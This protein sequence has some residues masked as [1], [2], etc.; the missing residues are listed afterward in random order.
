METFMSRITTARL[1]WDCIQLI[2]QCTV[3]HSSNSNCSVL[4]MS[5]LG[6]FLGISVNF[7]FHAADIDYIL[8]YEYLESPSPIG[9]DVEKHVSII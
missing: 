2:S 1:M 4:E 8:F 6:A 3:I 7:L 5:L 9:K